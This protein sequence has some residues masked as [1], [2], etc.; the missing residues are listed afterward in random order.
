MSAVESIAK[1]HRSTLERAAVRALTFLLGVG[2]APV[3]RGLLETR[4]YTAAEHAQGWKLLRAVD[5][6]VA[7]NDAPPDASDPAFRDAVARLDAWDNQNLPILDLALRRREPAVHGFLF[8]GGLA[9]ADGAES[10]RVVATFFDRIDTIASIA[11]GEADNDTDITPK[12]AKGALTLLA[13]RGVDAAERAAVQRWLDLAQRGADPIAPTVDADDDDALVALHE[14]VTEWSLVARKVV[15]RKAH[16]IALGL[17]EKKPAK[18][19]A[20]PQPA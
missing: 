13:S 7:A 19:K 15:T 5:P 18:P 11:E 6:T 4:G 3:I 17:A 20:P 8:A 10:V 9:P 2:R 16:L 1:P 14:W 12:Q